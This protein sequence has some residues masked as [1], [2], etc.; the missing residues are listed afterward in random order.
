MTLF[1]TSKLLNSQKGRRCVYCDDLFLCGNNFNPKAPTRDHVTPQRATKAQLPGNIVIACKQC[2]SDKG[3]KYLDRW[4][5]KLRG[6]QDRRAP[7][8]LAFVKSN[9]ELSAPPERREQ[10]KS[11]LDTLKETDHAEA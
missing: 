9:I 5:H 7:I 3:A 10:L 4:L 1:P 2:N 8:V 6:K 11:W